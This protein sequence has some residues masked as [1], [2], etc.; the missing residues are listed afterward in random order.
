ML[1]WLKGKVKEVSSKLGPPLDEHIQECK[2]SFKAFAMPYEV[3]FVLDFKVDDDNIP[4]GCAQLNEDWD[5]KKWF[6]EASPIPAHLFAS[7]K[8]PEEDH[9]SCGRP[10][11][12]VH[13]D[14]FAEDGHL[15]QKNL[16]HCLGKDFEK[17]IHQS[18]GS[19]CRR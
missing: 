1:D 13:V 11:H 12:A 8:V 5:S 15:W 6:R 2:T 10:A 17:W 14:T 3:G 18:G 4:M 16:L 7:S 19:S 9:M